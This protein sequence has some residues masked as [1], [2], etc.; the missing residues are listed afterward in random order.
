MPSK[1]REDQ[2]ASAPARREMRAPWRAPECDGLQDRKADEEVAPSRWLIGSGRLPNSSR[3]M[4]G[5]RTG[6]R[7]AA[8]RAVH[9]RQVL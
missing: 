3:P 7:R 4:W 1:L 9:Q 6:R 2:P 8:R 5:P